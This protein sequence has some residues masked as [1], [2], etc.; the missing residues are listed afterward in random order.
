MEI[1]KSIL[2][3]ISKPL[4]YKHPCSIFIAYLYYENMRYCHIYNL[5]DRYL[6]RDKRITQ[7]INLR[8]RNKSYSLWILN[9][10]VKSPGI[11]NHLLKGCTKDPTVYFSHL[12]W[13]KKLTPVSKL[14]IEFLEKRQRISFSKTDTSKQVSSYRSIPTQICISGLKLSIQHFSKSMKTCRYYN[15]VTYYFNAPRKKNPTVVFFHHMG[16]GA[17]RHCFALDTLINKGH[18]VLVIDMPGI[19][20]SWDYQIPHRATLLQSIQTLINTLKIDN[21]ILYGDA[22]GSIL[23]TQFLYYC[24]AIR[25]SIHEIY[26]HHPMCFLPCYATW[27]HISPNSILRD[28]WSDYYFNSIDVVDSLERTFLHEYKSKCTVCLSKSQQLSENL[29]EYLSEYLLERYTN[30]RIVNCESKCLSL[31]GCTCIEKIS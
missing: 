8:T 26:Y 31:S 9:E 5:L 29:S 2:Y 1:S 27:K 11:I 7:L 20:G 24:P 30:I 16:F 12:C 13:K 4:I 21:L 18:G 17:V 15:G 28:T 25:K 3:A 23:M 10:L 22:F 6:R 19:S 14:L